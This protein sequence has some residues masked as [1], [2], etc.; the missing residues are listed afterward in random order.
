MLCRYLVETLQFQVQDNT[1]L[2]NLLG[3]NGILLIPPTCM[4]K[5]LPISMATPMLITPCIEGSYWSKYN[6]YQEC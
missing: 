1:T 3:L 6:T 5:S 2:L 4:L